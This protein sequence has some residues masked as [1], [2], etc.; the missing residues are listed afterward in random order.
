MGFHK[1]W[2][3]KDSLIQRYRSEGIAGI[4]SYLR[5]ADAFIT[6]DNLSE[7]VVDLFNTYSMDKIEKWNTISRLISDASIK[8]GFNEKTY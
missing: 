8:E 3:A 7:D 2:I 5:N 4:E 1:R 6:S